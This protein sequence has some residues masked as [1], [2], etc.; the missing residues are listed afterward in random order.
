MPTPPIPGRNPQPATGDPRLDVTFAADE[1]AIAAVVDQVVEITRHEGESG[2]EMEVGLALTEALANAVR[3][4]CKNDPT[5]TV[6]CRVSLEPGRA[7]L[8]VVRDSGPGFDPDAIP[9]PMEGDNINRDHGR[10]IY[11]IR[12]LMDEVHYERHGTELHMKKQI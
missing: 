7:L 3:H 11:M 5:K 10:G 8:I 2:K 12:Q 9:N 1:K 4:G 6:H